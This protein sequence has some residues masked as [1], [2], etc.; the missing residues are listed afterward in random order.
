MQKPIATWNPAN[1]FWE[2][3]QAD[4][5][6][7][8]SEPYSA[9]FPTSGMTRS[10]QL[11]PLPLSAPAT[12]ESGYSLLPT[13][14]VND[15]GDGKTVAWWDEWTSKMKAKT[16]NGNGHGNSLAIEAKRHYP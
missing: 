16:G 4:L 13:P 6:S 2:T 1:Q 12:D 3:D 14:A 10:G 15:M 11:L 9:T 8:H 5:F 7:E